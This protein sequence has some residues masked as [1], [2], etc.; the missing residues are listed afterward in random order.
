[1]TLACYNETMKKQTA[2]KKATI[3]K[4]RFT[5]LMIALAC[6]VLMLCS[7]GIGLSVWRITRDGIHTPGDFLKSPFLIAICIFG[8]V[9]MISVLIRSRYIVTDSEF[10]AQF[11]LIKSKYAIKEITSL[12]L[13]TDTRKLAVYMGE[14]FF[15]VVIS[16]EWNNDLVQALRAVKPD[17]EFNFTLSEKTD[18]KK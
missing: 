3:F 14:E 4:Y 7:V 8:I 5:P 16:P 15:I 18:D 13:D 2:P 10:I 11:G 1:M 12:T 17:I 9:I 6:A